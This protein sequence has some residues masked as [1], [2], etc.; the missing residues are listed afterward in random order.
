M[1]SGVITLIRFKWKDGQTDGKMDRWQDRW[2]DEQLKNI[3]ALAPKSW[4]WH[5]KQNDAEW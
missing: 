1:L 5:K 4:W 3:M 2:T